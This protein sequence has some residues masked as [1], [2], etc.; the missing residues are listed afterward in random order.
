MNTLFSLRRHFLAAVAFAFS[1]SF[2]FLAVTNGQNQ[3]TKCEVCD[4]DKK[5][6]T[7]FINCDKVASYLAKHPEDYAGPCNNVTSEKPPK[8][9]KAFPAR[10]TPPENNF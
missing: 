8:P 1:M 5:P 7:K 4:N 9:P 2:V 10:R 6:K 3:T